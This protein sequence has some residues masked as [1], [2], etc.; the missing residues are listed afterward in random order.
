MSGSPHEVATNHCDRVLGGVQAA[1]PP[2]AAARPGHRLRARSFEIVGDGEEASGGGSN[3]KAWTLRNALFLV[4]T[5]S[6]ELRPR[7]PRGPARRVHRRRP[8]RRRLLPPLLRR[9]ATARGDRQPREDVRLEGVK[10]IQA[11]S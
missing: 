6:G 9:P 10:S 2:V 11:D 8:R 5:K 4:S 1:L 7:R 3:K